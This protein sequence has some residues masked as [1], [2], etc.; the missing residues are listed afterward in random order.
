[1]IRGL[2][3]D[4]G[5]RRGCWLARGVPGWRPYRSGEV[6]YQSRY[7]ADGGRVFFDSYDPLVPKDV[8]GKQDVYEWEADGVGC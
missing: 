3:V 2:Q 7:L 1:V 5:V 8:N 6:R 4:G